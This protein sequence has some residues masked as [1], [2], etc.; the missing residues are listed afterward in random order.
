[1]CFSD[2]SFPVLP[3]GKSLPKVTVSFAPGK[4]R[5]VTYRIKW[6]EFLP[7]L[8]FISPPPQIGFHSPR[9]PLLLS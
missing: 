4:A 5:K 2:F 6:L 1:M 9:R 3:P 7:F 8:F